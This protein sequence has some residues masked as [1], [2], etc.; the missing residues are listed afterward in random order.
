MPHAYQEQVQT[1]IRRLKSEP[2]TDV[3]RLPLA[4]A[5]PHAGATWNA[6]LEPVGWA[7]VNAE[8]SVRLLAQ[9]REAAAN[10]FPAVFPVTMEGTRRWLLK[11]LL[12]TPDRL[13]YWVVGSDYRKIGHLGLFRF[14]YE[15]R[16]VELDNVIRGVSAVLPGVME[17]AVHTLLGWTYEQFQ[18]NNILLRVFSDNPRAI[19][20]YER[21]GFAEMGRVPLERVVEGDVT[22]W[23]E[24]TEPS[25]ATSQRYFVTMQQS[26][27]AWLASRPDRKRAA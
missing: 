6:T 5:L 12:D 17:A 14:D 25:R 21:C 8:D 1:I 9:W 18:V 7:D 19:R 23:V 10:A 13:L 2:P 4:R 24:V 27:A 22:R 20:L 11:Q 16:Q 15:A 3:T 26:R